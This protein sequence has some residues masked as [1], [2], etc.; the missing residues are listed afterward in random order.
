[1][2]AFIISLLCAK[3]AAGAATLLAATLTA[4]WLFLCDG[5]VRRAPP[6][7]SPRHPHLVSWEQ[8]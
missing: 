3:A 6:P 7:P 4:T 1:M 8:P 5:C 2:E